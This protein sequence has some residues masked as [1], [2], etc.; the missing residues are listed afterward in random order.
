MYSTFNPRQTV[1]VDLGLKYVS[2]S[3][4]NRLSGENV[5]NGAHTHTITESCSYL[6]A[7]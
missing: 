6:T 1:I 7:K 4:D 3:F 5:K 2:E